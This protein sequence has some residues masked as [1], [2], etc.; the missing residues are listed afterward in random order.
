ML[1]LHREPIVNDLAS[2]PSALKH[3]IPSDAGR[4]L[5]LPT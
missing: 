4:L 1:K 3:A 5:N 2:P